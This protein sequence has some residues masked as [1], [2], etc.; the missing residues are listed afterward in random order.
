MMAFTP[1]TTIEDLTKNGFLITFA[2][3]EE[4]KCNKNFVRVWFRLRNS[5]PNKQKKSFTT[6]RYI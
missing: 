2:S 4:L 1:W 6:I 5:G 3:W